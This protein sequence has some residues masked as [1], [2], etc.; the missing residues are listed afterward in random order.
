MLAARG[1]AHIVVATALIDPRFREILTLAQL[2]EN[3]PGPPMK[4]RIDDVHERLLPNGL[5]I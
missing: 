3:R 1:A 4:M 5:K 2:V